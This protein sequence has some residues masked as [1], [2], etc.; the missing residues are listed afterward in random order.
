MCAGGFSRIREISRHQAQAR[1]TPEKC[2]AAAAI[3]GSEDPAP[4]S[5][6]RQHARSSCDENLRSSVPPPI[7]RSELGGSWRRLSEKQNIFCKLTPVAGLNLLLEKV[8]ISQTQTQIFLFSISVLLCAFMN[9]PPSVFSNRERKSPRRGRGR[10]LERMRHQCN[11]L[12]S[13]HLAQCAVLF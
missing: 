4:V 12:T 10:T 5:V 1:N 8:S 7:V 3:L 13:P 11:T 2:E 6:G 9:P